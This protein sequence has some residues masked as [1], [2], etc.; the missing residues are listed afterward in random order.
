MP[1]Q[2]DAV[3]AVQDNTVGNMSMSAMVTEEENHL[4]EEE[5]DN[6]SVISSQGK[7]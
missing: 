4:L 3:M 6:V 5:D 2:D 1:V 7:R